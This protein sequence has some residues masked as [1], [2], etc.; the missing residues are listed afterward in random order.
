MRPLREFTAEYN[1]A[2]IKRLNADTEA[3]VLPANA[4]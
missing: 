3:E 2:D 1:V 4:G